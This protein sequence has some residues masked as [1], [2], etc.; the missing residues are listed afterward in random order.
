MVLLRAGPY[1]R[2]SMRRLAIPAVALLAL[3]VGGAL[4]A[5]ALLASHQA[6]APLALRT[7]GPGGSSGALSGTW[8]VGAGS[9][10]GYRAREQFVNQPS[11]SEAVATTTSVTGGFTIVQAASGAVVTGL[12]VRTDLRNLQSQDRYASFQTYQRDFF[13]RK[14]YLESDQYPIAEFKAGSQALPAVP[15]SGVTKMEIRGTLRVHGVDRPETAFIQGTAVGAGLEVV[16]TIGVD[17]RDF[18]IAPP[19]I[20]FTRAEPVLTVEFK[21]ELRRS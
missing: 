13:V 2:D 16:G 1:D 4:G 7:P 20:S 17:M 3:L 9:V 18:G 15:A 8:R 5:R 14:I 19:D 10:A 6:P 12:D 21:L 11:P